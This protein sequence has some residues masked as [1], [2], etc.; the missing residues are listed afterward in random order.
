MR[1]DR[2]NPNTLRI[3]V[4]GG[5]DFDDRPMLSYVL[6]YVHERRGVAEVVHGGGRGA[7]QMANRWAFD[8]GVHRTE[9]RAEWRKYGSA[10]ALMIRNR[11]MFD[12]MPHGV[13]AFPG[14]TRSRAVV[15]SAREGSV[16]VLCAEAVYSKYMAKLQALEPAICEKPRCESPP[17]YPW[18]S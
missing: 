16:P 4:C 11:R 3:I 7:E 1:V 13:V 6:W 14:G 15:Q 8:H 18:P 17:R 10:K 9:V 5:R 2:R 12:L